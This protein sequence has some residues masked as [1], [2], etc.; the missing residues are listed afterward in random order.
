MSKVP[1]LTLLVDI[2]KDAGESMPEGWLFLPDDRQWNLNTKGVMIDIDVL[3][4][5]ELA[6]DDT[7]VFAKQNNLVE[8]IDGGT[9]TEIYL[10]AA[11]LEDP[12]TDETLLEAFIYYYRFD[13]FL[14][15]VG[16]PDP[17]PTEVV[18]RNLDR[19]FYNSLGGEDPAKQCKH[20]NC[21]RGTVKF[22]AFCRVHHFE[23][24]EGKPCPFDD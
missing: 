14:P 2:L 10:S 18:I 22:S 9:L 19:E 23:N 24:I 4:D 11:H 3:D 15:E 8:T 7:P 1:Q 20:E 21:E 5:S 16:A 12:P 6:D 13:A 17:P